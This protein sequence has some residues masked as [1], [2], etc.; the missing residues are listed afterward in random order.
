MP[1]L[2]RLRPGAMIEQAKNEI[3]PLISRIV[4]MFP[5]TMAPSWNAD[6]R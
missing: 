5:Y 4:P 2:G 3:H 1:V 6:L